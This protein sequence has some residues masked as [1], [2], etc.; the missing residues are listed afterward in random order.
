MTLDELIDLFTE[1]GF[2]PK[3]SGDSM[4]MYDV[5]GPRAYLGRM[6][7]HPLP[8]GKECHAWVFDDGLMIVSQE[9]FDLI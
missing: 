2:P 3:F 4:P 8:D 9:V 6:V 1:V 5:K 7:P